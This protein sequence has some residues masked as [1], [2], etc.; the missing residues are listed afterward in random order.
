MLFSVASSSYKA[1]NAAIFIVI[2][3]ITMTAWASPCGMLLVRRQTSSAGPSLG[4]SLACL[5][6]LL[7]VQGSETPYP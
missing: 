3:S 4:C 5:E 7:E 2:V 1:F 6:T